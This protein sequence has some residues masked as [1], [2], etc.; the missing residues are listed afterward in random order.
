MPK[1]AHICN[2]WSLVGHPSPKKEWSLEKKIAAV[3]AAG[4]DGIT[5]ALTPEHARLAKKYKLKHLLGFI[6][7]NSGDAKQYAKAIKA[8]KAAGA[9]QI[10]VQ[11]DDEDTKPSVAAKNW[12]KMVK[13]ADKIGGVVMSLEVHRDTCT[14]TPEKTYEIAKLYKKATGKMIKIN[15]DFS[16]FAVVKHIHPGNYSS[17]LLKYPKLVQ[18]GEQSHC[19]PFNG[20]HCQVSVTH[21]GKLTD[22]VKSYLKFTEDLFR[23]W[24]SA[25]QNADRTLYVCPELGPYHAGGAGYNITG[26]APAW[27]DAAILR[28]ELAK[29]WNRA[30]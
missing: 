10:N 21:N 18:N 20:H 25:K 22:E 17:Y 19:R 26:L 8:Q 30:K 7:D 28:K 13:E 16:H 6:S 12:I 1:I 3:A 2:L 29:A 4:F 9:V 11:L 5:T 23:C 24:K 15:F 27:P 14:E